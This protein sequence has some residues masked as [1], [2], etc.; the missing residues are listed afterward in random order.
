MKYILLLRH[1]KSSWKD[2]SLSDHDRPLNKRGKSTAPI[3]GQRL[4][5]KE[6]QPQHIISSTAKRAFDTA[7][8]VANKINIS[9]EDIE[10]KGNLFHAWPDE[11]SEII[12]QCDD[13][14]NKLMVVGHNPGMIM[15]ANDLLKSRR[16]EN[17]PTAGLVT[18]SIDI[19]N[20][21]EILNTENITC[22]LID[23]DYPK[24]KITV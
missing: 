20:W 15:Y 21:K 19:N 16:F 10:V 5:I 24:L 2:T 23:Y 22:Q 6:Y 8:I 12:A 1:A 11:I 14:I 13:L 3:M 4:A 17:I 7:T 9:I 18:I